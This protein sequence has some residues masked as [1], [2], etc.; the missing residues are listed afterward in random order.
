MKYTFLA[1]AV[2]F[3]SLAYLIF[4]YISGRPSNL[5]WYSM[6]SGGLLL[7]VINTYLFTKSLKNLNLGIAYP[8]FS[9]ASITLIVLISVLIFNEKISSINVIGALV[10]IVGIVLLTR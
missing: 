2:L 6:F 4:K 1:F 9:A 10:I 7:G 8:I 3:N 5:L